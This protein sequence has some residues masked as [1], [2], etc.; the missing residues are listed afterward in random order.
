VHPLATLIAEAQART[1]VPEILIGKFREHMQEHG[2]EVS[3]PVQDSRIAFPG[4]LALLRAEAGAIALR[5]EAETVDSLA[6]AKSTMAGHLDAFAPGEALGIVWHGAGAEGPGQRPHNFRALRVAR[7]T[8]VTPRMRRL[9]LTGE[10]LARFQAEALHV[11]LLIPQGEAG[12]EPRWPQMS[13]SGQ[14]IFDGCA[15]VRRTYTIR[16]IDPAAGEM[17]IDFVLHG[18]GSPGSRFALRAGPGDWLGVTGPGGGHIPLQDWMLIAGDE[19]ALPAIA[20]SLEAMPPTAQGLAVIEVA[21]AAEEQPLARPAGIGLQWVHR[22]KAAY[23]A[24]LLDAVKAVTWPGATEVSAWA[25][26]EQATA[27]ALREHW[28]VERGLPRG[29]FRAAAYWR[30]GVEEGAARAEG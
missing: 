22:G 11:K 28:G 5:I 19:T 10:D 13:A 23:G 3:G 14:A 16:R 1:V 26:C 17:D 2:L 24:K 15:L 4:G 20:R 6:D 25:A 7:L 27:Q 29:R 9:T 12:I 8:E 18:D 30:Q 21:D